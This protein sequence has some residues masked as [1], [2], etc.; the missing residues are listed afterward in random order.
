MKKILRYA[1]IVIVLF[2][3]SFIFY[4]AFVI[5]SSRISTPGIISKYHETH[6]TDLRSNDLS[7]WQTRALIM[8]ED[9]NFF[10]HSGVDFSTPG[11]GITTISQ[12]L[13]KILYFN[14]FSP[15]LAKLKQTL[16][17]RFTFDPLISKDEQLSMFINMAY[18]GNMD[19]KYIFGF[20][21]AAKLYYKKQFKKLNKDEYL[22]LIAMLIAPDNFNLISRPKANKE[23]VRR[24]KLLISGKYHPKG[25]MDLY[26][27]PLDEDSRKGLPPAS[28]YPELYK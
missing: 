20:T 24:I 11:A 15:G 8:V 27:G 28:Y 14:D 4:S 19:G 2:T 22:S 3:I 21:N 16:I 12:G 9:P 18:L 5:I 1:L 6:K 13:V 7:E 17:A 23:R 25:L 10:K 26:Y